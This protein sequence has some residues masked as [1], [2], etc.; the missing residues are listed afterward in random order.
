MQTIYTVIGGNT[1]KLSG[2]PFSRRGSWLSLALAS[3]GGLE[4]RRSLKSYGEKREKVLRIT[5][6]EPFTD[7]EFT[8]GALK[9]GGAEFCF[10][11]A[12]IVRYRG[13]V[14]FEPSADFS[15]NDGCIFETE[16]PAEPSDRTFDECAADSERDFAE[17]YA[18]YPPVAE[19][20]EP[21]KRL[22]AYMIWA[23]QVSPRGL[24]TEPMFLYS[25]PD[26]TACFSWHQAYHAMALREPDA[27]VQALC[28]MFSVQDEFGELPDL[29]DDRYININATKPPVHGLA[30]LKMLERFGDRLTR[31]HC[32]TMYAGLAKLYNFWTTRDGGDIPSYHHG[33]ESGFDFTRMFSKGVPAQCPDILAY[34]ILLAE[35]LEKLAQRLGI[36]NDWRAKSDRLLKFLTSELWNGERFIAR[37]LH[38]GETA[39]TDE[40]EPFTPLILGKRLPP[41]ITEKLVSRLERDYA[42]PYGLQTAPDSGVI[43]GFS[44]AFL[45]PA[46]FDCGYAQLGTKLLRG[47]VEYEA[48]H[49][50]A[51]LFAFKG[52]LGFDGFSSLSALSAAEWL[53]CAALLREVTDEA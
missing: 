23:C 9:I 31:A 25:K 1:M 18:K 34:C 3:G 39:E 42:S 33:C 20:H 11:G 15:V 51:F 49:T 32:E 44:Q 19:R 29:L 22:C 5:L 26:D 38:T 48:E 8:A 52:E 41:E 37:N 24:M 45:L 36:A 7:A 53:S 47:Y 35:A 12:D 16:Y 40:L 50:P 2:V 14:A 13:D 21:M 17:W 10:D 43:I 6:P 28:S 30:A 27:A 46:L 4:L